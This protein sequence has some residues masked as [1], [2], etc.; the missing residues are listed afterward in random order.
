MA[1]THIPRFPK[2]SSRQASQPS[3]SETQQYIQQVLLWD[4]LPPSSHS[5]DCLRQAWRGQRVVQAPRK[6][7]VLTVH[8]NEASINSHKATITAAAE[9]PKI[10]HSLSISPKET[11]ESPQEN[12]LPP[13]QWPS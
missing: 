12:V 8:P 11:P 13:H 6:E 10:E 4:H 9:K 2:R 5:Q 3:S 1:V 7:E